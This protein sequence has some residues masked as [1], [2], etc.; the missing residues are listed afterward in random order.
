MTNLF[1]NTLIIKSLYITWL[2]FVEEGVYY[3][4]IFKEAI[5]NV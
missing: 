2:R 3:F 5:I 1:K 4:F